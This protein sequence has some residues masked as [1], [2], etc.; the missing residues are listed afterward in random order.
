MTN[1]KCQAKHGVGEK[2][3]IAVFQSYDKYL[4]KLSKNI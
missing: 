1:A 2:E 4:N 3:V